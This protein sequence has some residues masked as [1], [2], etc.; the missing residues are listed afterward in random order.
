[1]AKTFHCDFCG[2]EVS[3][4]EEQCPNCGRYFRAVKCPVC[5]YTG[6]GADFLKGCPSCGY[7]TDQDQQDIVKIKQKKKTFNISKPFAYISLFL[8]TLILMYLI[9]LFS[10]I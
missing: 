5:E 6:K 4:E 1:M 3:P 2:E 10:K 9:F 8:L 7:L